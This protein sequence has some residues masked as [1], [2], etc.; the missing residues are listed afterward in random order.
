VLSIRAR[1]PFS[2]RSMVERRRSFSGEHSSPS[3]MSSTM[4]STLHRCCFATTSVLSPPAKLLR[5]YTNAAINS[6]EC[7]RR[8]RG[9]RLAVGNDRR[10]LA[11]SRRQAVSLSDVQPYAHDFRLAQA[12][13]HSAPDVRNGRRRRFRPRGFVC[14]R[15][16]TADGCGARYF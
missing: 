9:R 1:R 4:C 6:P 5:C 11:G 12:A 8:R 16:R 10:I 14:F 15:M 3:S 7:W 2:C 13:R